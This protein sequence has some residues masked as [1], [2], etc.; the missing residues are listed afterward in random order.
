MSHYTVAVFTE[1]EGK[2]IDDLLAPFDENLEV[3]KYLSSTK[4]EFIE[5][6]KKYYHDYATDGP[7]AEYIKD[8]EG[9][10]KQ[11]DNEDHLKY[12]REEFPKKLKYTD[13]EI[14]KY[15]T[16][17][18]DDDQITEEG[19]WSTYNPK[20]KWDWYEIGGRWSNSLKLKDGRTVDSAPAK[21][22]DITPDPNHVKRL[23]RFWELYVEGKKPE[24]ESDK[25]LIKFVFFKK[26]YY[27]NK[28]KTKEKYVEVESAFHTWAAL[29]PDG[30]WLEPGQMGMFG[31]SDS[32]PIEEVLWVDKFKTIFKEAVKLNWNIT[33]VDCHI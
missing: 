22:V 33:I 2:T 11:Y 32:T 17:Y 1:N 29:T 21:D 31:M 19:I 28:Y 25:E 5:E 6:K 18:Y 23:E 8:P 15:E 9:Y 24:T 4:T 12:L 13:E 3:E 27:L 20:S 26:E 16:Q 14:W 10:A 30:E 7:Y